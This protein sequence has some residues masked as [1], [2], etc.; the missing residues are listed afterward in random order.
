MTSIIR[1][2]REFSFEMAHALLNHD[3]PC[4]NVHGHSYRLFVTV[5]GKPVHARS[6]PGNGMVMD[7]DDLKEIVRKEIISVFDHSLII[8]KYYDE[9]KKMLLRGMFE[10]LILADYQPTCENLIADFAE[11]IKKQL[12]PG[13]KLHSLK[14]Y[15]TANSYAEWFASDNE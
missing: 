7:F 13:I 6:D 2:T 3:G 11:R 15:E 5:S 10:N 4:R 14:L 12:P 8:S 9:E 1:I